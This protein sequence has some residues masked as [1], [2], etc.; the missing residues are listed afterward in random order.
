MKAALNHMVAPGLPWPA[1]FD[2]ARATG[3]TAIELRNDLG[4]PLFDGDS[5]EEVREAAHEAGLRIITLAELPRF[6]DFN[7][8]RRAEA[9]ALIAQAQACGAGGITLIPRND[10]QGRGNGERIANLRLALREL[11]PMLREAGL[12]GYIE[13]LGF[14]SSSLRHKSEA[15]DAIDGLG[16]QDCLALVHDTFHHV[17]AGGGAFYPDHTGILHVSAVVA[18]AVAL[19]QLTDAHRGLPVAGDRLDSAGQIAA[20]AAAGWDGPVSLEPFAPEVHALADPAPAIVNS[21][22]HVMAAGSEMPA[23]A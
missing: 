22:E 12:T 7:E 2:L 9:A 15:V 13:P 10:G 8:D 19:A 23:P 4:R 11:V 14:E 16:A 20:L 5:A 3:A 18:S 21:L 6:N 17:L 1:L